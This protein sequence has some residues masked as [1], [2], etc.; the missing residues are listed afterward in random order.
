MQ[1]AGEDLALGTTSRLTGSQQDPSASITRGTGS[2]YRKETWTKEVGD[3][4]ARLLKLPRGWDG[5]QGRAPSVEAVQFS[6]EVLAGSWRPRLTVP[7]IS[8]KSDGGLLIEW[9]GEDAE[10]TVEVSAPYDVYVS[11]EED[12]EI[13]ETVLRNDFSTLEGLL[14]LYV[15]ATS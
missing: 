1:Y 14:D 13:S 15:Q 12:D 7:D 9:T 3:R 10:L 6:L 4:L 8:P 5:Y 11:Y 2:A